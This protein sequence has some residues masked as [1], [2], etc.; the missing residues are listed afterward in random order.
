MHSKAGRLI[1]MSLGLV[2][3]PWQSDSV[4]FFW[5]VAAACL[6]PLL[7]DAV[8]KACS[9]KRANSEGENILFARYYVKD[10]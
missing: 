8:E 1:L 4:G 2:I 10:T 3:R 5:Q 6:R 7:A 9:P